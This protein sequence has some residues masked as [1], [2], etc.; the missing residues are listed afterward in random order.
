M[1]DRAEQLL[2]RVAGDFGE[3]KVDFKTLKS[4]LHSGI[5]KHFDGENSKDYKKWIK[6]VEVEV[7]S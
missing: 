2:L 6:S 3:I 4:E 1:A 7:D 5:V